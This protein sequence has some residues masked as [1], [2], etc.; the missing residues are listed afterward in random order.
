MKTGQPL[1]YMSDKESE[2]PLDNPALDTG[3]S[4]EEK[5][6][7]LTSRKQSEKNGSYRHSK[8]GI[9]LRPYTGDGNAE[10]YLKQFRMTAALANWSKNGGPFSERFGR[11]CS[12]HFD[13]RRFT[14]HAKIRESNQVAESQI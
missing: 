6:E 11:T 13:S 12:L 10:H 5:E 14:T 9:K 2:R 3:S 8:T 1:I 7:Q 4:N